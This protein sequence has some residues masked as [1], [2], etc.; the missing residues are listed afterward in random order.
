[1][2]RKLPMNEFA[3]RPPNAKEVRK[4]NEMARRVSRKL[5]EM[6]EAKTSAK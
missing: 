3:R 1:M 2:R 4:A 6:M 5:G